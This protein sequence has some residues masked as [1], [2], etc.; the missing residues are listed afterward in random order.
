[1]AHGPVAVVRRWFDILW[2]KR[3]P[4][5]IDELLTDESVRHSDEGPLRGPNDFR[6][7]QYE[8]L[9]AAFPTL[10]VMVEGMLCQGDEVLVRWSAIGIHTGDGLGMK[11]T[12]KPVTFR[13]M[14]WIRGKDGKLGEGWQTSNIVEVFRQLGESSKGGS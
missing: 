11:A 10:N 12:H 7:K 9:V 1:M 2:N 3:D 8:P 14:T 5:V 13:G 4:S 6:T